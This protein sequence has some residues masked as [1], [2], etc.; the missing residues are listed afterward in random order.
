MTK[1]S[2][3]DAKSLEI[4]LKSAASKVRRKVKNEIFTVR[5]EKGG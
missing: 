3:F 1:E 4:I 2:K 5:D